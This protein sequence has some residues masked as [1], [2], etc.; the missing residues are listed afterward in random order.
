[1][2]QARPPAVKA[3]AGLLSLRAM[4][5]PAV[6]GPVPVHDPVRAVPDG[7]GFP[8]RRPLRR[9]RLFILVFGA[10]TALVLALNWLRPAIYRSA[11]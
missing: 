10:L 3:G 8:P 5:T 11:A 1:M 4:N 6:A 9:G 7:G 2:K